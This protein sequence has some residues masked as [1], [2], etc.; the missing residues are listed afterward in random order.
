MNNLI[1]LPKKSKIYK[2]E[3]LDSNRWQGIEFRNDDIIIATS[4]KTGTTWMERILS[5]LIH[6]TPNRIDDKVMNAP[7]P[8]AIIFEPLAITHKK[9]QSIQHRRFFK[10]HIPL[11]GLE[12]NE[13]VKYIH[14]TRDTRDAFMSLMN[15]WRLISDFLE[16]NNRVHPPRF[17]TQG[18]IHELWR[19]YTSKSTFEWESD[20]WPYWSN[21]GYTESFWPYRFFPNIL[22]VH[23]NDLLKDLDGQMRRV[24][25]FLDISIPTE[26]ELWEEMVDAATFKS[27]K[28]DGAKLI[29]KFD[30]VFKG[31]AKAFLN[32]GKNGRWKEVFNEE[33]H[34]LYNQMRNRYD[35]NMMDWIEQGSIAIGSPQNR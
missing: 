5:L 10:T 27:M 35:S 4:M 18:D 15:H 19:K 14:V 30:K 23:F 13:Q 24:A 22:F 34:K 26:D 33:D 3:S 25:Q 11:D 12:F 8:D 28:R 2:N 17:E 21:N 20:G 29:P 6:Q 1:D 31:G 9:I 7:W 32:K 16:K